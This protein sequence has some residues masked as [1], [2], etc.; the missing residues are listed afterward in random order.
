MP[1]ALIIKRNERNSIHYCIEQWLLYKGVEVIVIWY[2]DDPSLL[3][4]DSDIDILVVDTEDTL[5]KLG[6]KAKIAVIYSG[7]SRDDVPVSF[8]ENIIVLH[9]R[10]GLYMLFRILEHYMNKNGLLRHTPILREEPKPP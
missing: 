6:L 10:T 7:M 9:R 3:G 1:R 8:D 5:K 4:F 2:Q